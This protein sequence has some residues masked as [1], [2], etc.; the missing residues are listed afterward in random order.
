MTVSMTAGCAD[1]TEEVRH[2]K[3]HCD[4]QGDR[5][6]QKKSQ[7]TLKRCKLAQF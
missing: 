4:T 2:S 5:M 1:H 7:S 3:G 6:C